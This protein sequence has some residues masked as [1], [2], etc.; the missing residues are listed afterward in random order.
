MPPQRRVPPRL[1]PRARRAH[2]PHRV[3]GVGEDL[4][5]H[6]TAG[7][8]RHAAHPPVHLISFSHP[9]VHLLSFSHPPLH[10]LSNLLLSRVYMTESRGV[11]GFAPYT[12]LLM[13]SR[14]THVSSLHTPT[15]PAPGRG[16]PHQIW[17]YF[18]IDTRLVSPYPDTTSCTLHPTPC[19]LRPAGT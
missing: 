18:L 1:Q 8:A 2:L 9:P 3:D 6:R 14:H 15:R 17:G 19:A 10:L 7:P 12:R 5:R 16:K 11:D 4:H 13:D